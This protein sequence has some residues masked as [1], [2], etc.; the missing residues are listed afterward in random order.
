M[1][2][3]VGQKI[4]K[5]IYIQEGDWPSD[6]DKDVGRMDTP[7]AAAEIIKLANLGLTFMSGNYDA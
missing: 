7:E 1:R 2:Y 3:R 4:P 5:N 6:E